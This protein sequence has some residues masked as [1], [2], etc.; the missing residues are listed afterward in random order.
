LP[1]RIAV[2][3]YVEPT[4]KRVKQAARQSAEAGLLVLVPGLVAWVAGFPLIFPSLGPTAYL[5]AVRP[6]ARTCRPRR[7]VGGHVIGVVAGLVAVFLFDPSV[8]IVGSL[9]PGSAAAFRL[10]ASGVLA[11]LL[12][13]G[14]MVATGLTHAPACAT[15]LIVS[16]G[17]LR[18]PGEVAGIVAA[19]GLLVAVHQAVSRVG[20]LTP[21]FPNGT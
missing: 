6:E 18:S 9:E 13:T 2:V 14:G 4:P 5:L 21:A 3:F 8:P 20:L 17:L 1:A 10:A 15:T 7:V 11:T 16:L 12:T 19:V